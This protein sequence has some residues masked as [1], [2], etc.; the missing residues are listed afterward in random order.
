MIVYGKMHCMSEVLFG[1]FLLDPDCMY[2]ILPM[3]VEIVN[4]IVYDDDDDNNNNNTNNTSTAPI[5]F[6]KLRS[7]AQ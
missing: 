5:S 4:G 2:I 6:I 3:Y 7:E 1:K